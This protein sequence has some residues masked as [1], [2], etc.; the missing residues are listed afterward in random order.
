MNTSYFKNGNF[1]VAEGNNGSQQTAWVEE[2]TDSQRGSDD[3]LM[4]FPHHR[5]KKGTNLTSSAP[6]ESEDRDSV[7]DMA[8]MAQIVDSN[9]GPDK[10]CQ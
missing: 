7:E 1:L 2:P 4:E 5:F 9:L 8:Y 10:F 3:L 6:R